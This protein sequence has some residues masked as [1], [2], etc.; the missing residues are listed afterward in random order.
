MSRLNPFSKMLD[1]A[2]ESLRLYGVPSQNLDPDVL[3]MEPAEHRYRCDA[4][5]LLPP[6]KIWSVFIQGEMGP[7]LI[8]VKSVVLQNATQLRFVE[9]DQVIEAFAPNRADETLEVAVLPRRARRGRMIADTH[10]SNA[11]G[12]GWTECSV[13]VA[14]QMT[15]PFSPPENVTHLPPHP[16]A[17]PIDI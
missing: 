3:M 9:H 2:K 13:T 4:A 10:R 6:S 17:I 7:D 12:I 11:M 8:V 1:D 16:L 14:N 5:G 15:R